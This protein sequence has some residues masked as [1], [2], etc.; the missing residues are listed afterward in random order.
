MSL[1]TQRVL[2]T[3]AGS[4]LGRATALRFAAQGARV[5][6]TD[7]DG[8]SPAE[9]LAL[10]EKEGGSGL[11]FTLDVTREEDFIAA[12]E[13]LL[14]EWDGLDVLVNNAGVASA[15]LIE[16]T[17]LADWDWI[18]NINLLGVVRGCKTFAPLFKAQKSG[19][20]VN[21]ASFAGIANPPNMASYNATKSAVIAVSETLL[22][23][24]SPEVGVT[25]VCPAFF[26]TNLM[27]S[28]RVAQPA[29][30]GTVHRWMKKS[31]VTADDV[32]AQIVR[33]VAKRQFLLLSHK[34]TRMQAAIKRASP[35][36][37]YRMVQKTRARMMPKAG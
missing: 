20:I 13:R 9:T 7:R 16:E 36:M 37:F 34:D 8:V 27:N 17:S 18:I 28:A 1:P 35:A 2:V 29:T 5:A 31:G 11:A 30:I 12:R 19:H 15:G 3:G 26:P 14:R 33:A 4:G 32:A 6:C 22:H 23:E 25:V 10:I 24:L 21:I